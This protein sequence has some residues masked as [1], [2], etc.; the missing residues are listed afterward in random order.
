MQCYR[1]REQ[2]ADVVFQLQAAKY[3]F[4]KPEVEGA[5]GRREAPGGLMMN[6]M[7]DG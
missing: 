6:Q 1:Q 2:F 7:V 3:C 4:G 5:A